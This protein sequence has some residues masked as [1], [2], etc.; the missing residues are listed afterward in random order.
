MTLVFF[1]YWLVE[2]SY[3][4]FF[5][6]NFQVDWNSQSY[7]FHL[8]SDFIQRQC[9]IKET[10]VEMILTNKITGKCSILGSPCD[11]VRLHPLTSSSHSQASLHLLL[12]Y[13]SLY[14]NSDTHCL[15]CDQFEIFKVGLFID[16][17]YVQ[18]KLFVL[19]PHPLQLRKLYLNKI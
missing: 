7:L 3:P 17:I 13:R 14:Y 19:F 2:S 12:W 16:F 1:C 18:V 8:D 11:E 10:I 9:S 5:H 4:A 6:L 15:A